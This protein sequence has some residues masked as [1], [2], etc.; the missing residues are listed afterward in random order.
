MTIK[1]NVIM[2]IEETDV[3]ARNWVES[4]KDKV[5]SQSSISHGIT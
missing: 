4:A 2:Y 3:I 5:E 1:A